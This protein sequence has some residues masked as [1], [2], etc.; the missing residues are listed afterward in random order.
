MGVALGSVS[1]SMT[2][3][4]EVLMVRFLRISLLASAVLLTAVSAAWAMQPTVV[5]VE[6]NGDGTYTYHFKIRIDDGIT[7][8]SGTTE[9]NPDFFTIFN[10]DGFVPDSA[11]SPQGWTFSTS[12]N[13]VT[14]LRGGKALVNPEDIEGIPNL[15][16]SR[17]GPA[18]KGPVEVAGFSA[19]TQTVGTMVGEYG[20]QVTRAPGTVN[21]KE[22]KE[23]KEARIGSITTPELKK[24]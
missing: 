5:Q 17:T 11:K 3:K 15:T 12:T 18:L 14:P 7:V 9:P 23:G 20:S 2:K 24:K 22:L 4:G 13:G 10:F 19:R 16:W 8:E 21:P 1:S 6:K